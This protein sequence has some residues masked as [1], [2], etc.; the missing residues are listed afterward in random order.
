MN[1]LIR[2]IGIGFVGG[3]LTIVLKHEKPEFAVMS[4]LITVLVI[5][6]DITSGVGETIRSI[7]GLIAECGV[8]TEY[9]SLAFKAVA[10]AY[11]AQYASEILRDSGESAIASKVETAGKV[12]ILSM[13]MPVMASFLRMCV[14]VVNGI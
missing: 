9:F 1:E 8:N 14:K 12:C 2:D 7:K 5:F 4:C 6:A 3:I 11:I 10:M 13:A